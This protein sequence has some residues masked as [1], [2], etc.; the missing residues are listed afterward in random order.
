MGY[1]WSDASAIWQVKN[2][3]PN[4]PRTISAHDYISERL[5]EESERHDELVRQLEEL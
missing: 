2:G 5:A 4:T 1:T 3:E